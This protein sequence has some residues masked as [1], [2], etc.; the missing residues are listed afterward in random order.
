MCFVASLYS[1]VSAS[2]H[3]CMLFGIYHRKKVS[4]F[5][6]ETL[7]HFQGRRKCRAYDLA[8]PRTIWISWRQ[9][10]EVKPCD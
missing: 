7:S 8:L 2:V 5:Y 1:F 9:Q 4:L 6:I 3:C 10:P